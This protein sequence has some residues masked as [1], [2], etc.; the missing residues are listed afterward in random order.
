[1]SA[2]SLHSVA[3]SALTRSP[4]NTQTASR[5]GD[6]LRVFRGVIKDEG[7]LRA[8]Y[9]GLWPNLL[10]NS[11]GWAVFFLFYQ[12]IKDMMQARRGLGEHLSS[13]EYFSAS[14]ASGMST[15][16]SMVYALGR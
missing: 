13:F 14:G 16:C 9:R 15:P 12:N 10:G 5:A 11:L 2:E 6:S 4:V 7:G 1:M 3:Y 8:L